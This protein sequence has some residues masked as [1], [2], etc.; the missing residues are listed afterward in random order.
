MEAVAR[1]K[2]RIVATTD[3]RGRKIIVEESFPKRAQHMGWFFLTARDG[4]GKLVADAHFSLEHSFMPMKKGHLAVAGIKVG[5][6]LPGFSNPFLALITG[7]AS[8]SRVNL[9]STVYSM[10]E[11]R[12]THA[13]L[14]AWHSMHGFRRTCV[15]DDTIGNDNIMDRPFN[16]PLHEALF[17]KFRIAKGYALPDALEAYN[18]IQGLKGKKG[19]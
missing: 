15:N 9:I 10:D 16:A 8:R 5:K 11:K 13:Q 12:I 6:Y 14:R 18:I 1:R 7:L 19:E 2:S 17:R 3:F 4:A